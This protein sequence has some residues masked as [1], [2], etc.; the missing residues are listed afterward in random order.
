MR[1][2]SQR[3]QT[4][5]IDAS[6]GGSLYTCGIRTSGEVECWGAGKDEELIGSHVRQSMAPPGRFLEIAAGDQITCGLRPD[7]TI[8]CWGT[9]FAVDDKPREPEPPCGQFVQMSAQGGTG[10]AV[11]PTGRLAC[12]PNPLPWSTFEPT[13]EPV[14]QVSLGVFCACV[15]YTTGE[16][17]CRV[18]RMSQHPPFPTWVDRWQR[19]RVAAVA[20][21]TE[22]ANTAC[23]ILED[24]TV[25]C[26]AD[27][28]W[29][30]ADSGPP[31]GRTCG[32]RRGNI[33]IHLTRRE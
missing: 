7:F 26:M 2:E 17:D 14:E 13:A 4:C 10:C 20:C 29:D 1:T 6:P 3:D 19:A 30:V 8:E 5:V 32:G 11:D 33:A 24:G 16:A 18:G 31:S 25:E 12:W 21:G 27:C 9:T 28:Q 23:A 22:I 15:L